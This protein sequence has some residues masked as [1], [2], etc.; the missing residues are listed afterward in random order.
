MV[1]VGSVHRG[2]VGMFWWRKSDHSHTAS[3][4]HYGF[5]P[6]EHPHGPT[7]NGPDGH[8]AAL[9][10]EAE[11]GGRKWQKDSKAELRYDQHGYGNWIALSPTMKTTNITSTITPIQQAVIIMDL[12]HQNIPTD[13][14]VMGIGSRFLIFLPFRGLAQGSMVTVGSVHR[15]SVAPGDADSRVTDEQRSYNEDHEYHLDDHSHTASSDELRYDQHGYGNWIALSY[16]SSFS[17]SRPRQHGDRRVM[18][19]APT[20]KT[21][22]ITSTITP[23]QQAV[24]IMDLRHQNIG[25]GGWEKVAEG[26][27]SGVALRSAWLW[28]LDR[29]FLFFFLQQAVIIMDLRHQNIPTDPR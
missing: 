7:M 6:P 16:F 12:R 20:M 26:F 28:E 21:T 4:D 5:A 3:S 19:S 18:N 8:H 23:I 25:G 17:R 27:E 10:E 2:S 14:R 24:I 9:I 15:G 29:A 1:T 22:N 11:E 13:P